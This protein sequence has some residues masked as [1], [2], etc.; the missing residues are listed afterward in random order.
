MTKMAFKMRVTNLKEVLSSFSRI[1]STEIKSKELLTD[2]GNDSKVRIQ[3]QTRLGK[4]LTKEKVPQPGLSDKYIS[5]RRSLAKGIKKKNRNGTI[6]KPD[7]DFFK[8]NRSNLTL[9]GQLL[10]SL[11]ISVNQSSGEVSIRPSGQRDDGFMNEDVARD[12]KAQGRTFLGLDNV[13]IQLIKKRILD[14]IRRE[15]IKKR[16]SKR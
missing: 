4:D 7:P 15:I 10:K 2:I 13:G 14:E 16:F 3:Q 1:F 9:T 6:I 5:F 12:L 11:E 8:P